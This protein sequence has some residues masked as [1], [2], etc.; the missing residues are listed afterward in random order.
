VVLE[1]GRRVVDGR[2]AALASQ[3]DDAEDKVHAGGP[4]MLVEA[5]A[6]DV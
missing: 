1:T 3:R 2:R 5:G 4:F 6:H